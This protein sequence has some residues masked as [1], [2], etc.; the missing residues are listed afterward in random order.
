[1]IAQT[2]RRTQWIRTQ[3]ENDSEINEPEDDGMCIDWSSD[4]QRIVDSYE[5]TMREFGFEPS[6][7]LPGGEE[8]ARQTEEASA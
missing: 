3:P 7:L 8:P 6:Q 1:M 5:K 2:V 4:P